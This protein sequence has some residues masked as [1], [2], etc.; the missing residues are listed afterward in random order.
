MSLRSRLIFKFTVC[1][2]SIIL[3]RFHF[4]TIVLT[5]VQMRSSYSSQLNEKKREG[6]TWHHYEGVPVQQI[7]FLT[8]FGDA[9]SSVRC[10]VLHWVLRGSRSRASW[11]KSATNP[12]FL[13]V[14]CYN[15]V[16]PSFLHSIYNC[17]EHIH[18]NVIFELVSFRLIQTKSILIHKQSGS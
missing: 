1:D 7:S 16:Q 4:F 13:S 2:T 18:R 3:T 14:M 17:S 15:Y 9:V 11:A 8:L 5:K 6:R 12:H 10:V